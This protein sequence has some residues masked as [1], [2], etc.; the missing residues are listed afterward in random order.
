MNGRIITASLC[1]VLFALV[2]SSAA[3][4]AQGKSGD[5]PI[6]PGSAPTIDGSVAAPEWADAFVTVSNTNG[7]SLQSLADI[8]SSVPTPYSPGDVTQTRNITVYTKRDNTNLYFAF[9]VPDQ[10]IPGP[11]VG[12]RIILVF[13]PTKGGGTVPK[14]TDRKLDFRT[15][16]NGTNDAKKLWQGTGT[17]WGTAP[18]ESWT[19]TSPAPTSGIK[20]VATS[21]ASGY[22]VE[23][24]V[25]LTAL[26]AAVPNP[27]PDIGFSF[28][29]LNDLNWVFGAD[30]MLTGTPWPDTFDM[31]SNPLDLDSSA[32]Y[33]NYSGSGT[34]LPANWDQPQNWGTAFLNSVGESLYFANTSYAWLSDAIKATF[35]NVSKTVDPT[36]LSPSSTD[37]FFYQTAAP[38]PCKLRLRALVTR[39]GGNFP[40]QR[41]VLFLWADH[42]A[43]PQYWRFVGI[44]PV[45]DIPVPGGSPMITPTDPVDFDPSTFPTL[46]NH[47]CVKAFILPTQ[48]NDPTYNLTWLQNIGSTSPNLSLVN[49]FVAA[50]HLDPVK[51]V[52]QMNLNKIM[53]ALA[54]CPGCVAKGPAAPGATLAMSA[55]EAGDCPPSA[56]LP[57]GEPFITIDILSLGSASILKANQ[58]FAYIRATG[59]A[60]KM[61]SVP[62]LIKERKLDMP[63]NVSNAMD[64]KRQTWVSYRVQLPGNIPPFSFTL[65]NLGSVLGPGEMS[66][67]LARIGDFSGSGLEASLHVGAAIPHGNLGKATNAG[68]M[69]T[70]DLEY[71][72]TKYLSGEVLLGAARF[73]GKSGGG[74]TTMYE[75]SVNAKVYLL[76]G[77]WRPFLNA[78]GGVY[79]FHPGKDDGGVNVGAGLR[80]DASPRIALEASYSF[81]DAIQSGADATFSGIQV[82]AVYKF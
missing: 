21:N 76:N 42:G 16:R 8:D 30:T 79:S 54:A 33:I 10:S 56:P 81:H 51:H 47:P 65:P 53:P 14:L 1:S 75:A 70:L 25:P 45:L 72:A 3:W 6:L 23:I 41:Q 69:S 74:G 15:Q 24:L 80:F 12:D 17:D 32:N 57:S 44:A 22:S 50:Y 48:L 19:N 60:R 46:T 4:A 52:A 36:T 31:G 63:F 78:G 77:D 64:T 29:I 18:I 73:G 37:W 35:C 38:G 67:L 55:E 39:N 7:A 68:F 71:A 11:T 40:I 82:G 43:N 34:F 59:G 26:W 2:G 9:V 13:D 20:V 62:H 66:T 28:A 27:L 61:I 58:P 5:M 49:S